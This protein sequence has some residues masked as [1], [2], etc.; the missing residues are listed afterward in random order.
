MNV[1]A[2]YIVVMDYPYATDTG[3]QHTLHT[4]HSYDHDGNKNNGKM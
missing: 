3:I 1:V 2:G 4:L